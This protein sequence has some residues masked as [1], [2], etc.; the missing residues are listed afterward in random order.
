MIFLNKYLNSSILGPQT[1]TEFERIFIFL[2]LAVTLDLDTGV[3]LGIK[4]LIKDKLDYK[5]VR[6]TPWTCLFFIFF[7][8]FHGGISSFSFPMHN[9][10]GTFLSSASGFS[11][12]KQDNYKLRMKVNVKHRVKT[13][14]QL[15]T[16]VV[17]M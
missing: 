3:T 1:L 2:F 15:F 7:I 6:L 17:P 16:F 10:T 9:V 13:V 11:S 4:E 14:K 12:I 8:L 5:L